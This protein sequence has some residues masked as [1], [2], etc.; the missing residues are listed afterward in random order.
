M[1]AEEFLDNYFFDKSVFKQNIYNKQVF[2][3]FSI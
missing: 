3:D 2:M 1:S